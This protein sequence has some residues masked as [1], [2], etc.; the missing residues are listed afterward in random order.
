MSPSTARTPENLDALRRSLEFQTKMNYVMQAI[1]GAGSFA[2]IMPQVEKEILGLINAERVTVFQRNRSEKQLVS[3]H[4][5]AHDVEE[6][7]VPLT[8]SSIVGYVA[9]SQSPVRIDDVYDEAA[10]K[11]IHPNLRFGGRHLDKQTGYRT[12]SIIAVPIKAHE[13]LLGVLQLINHQGGGSFTDKE[14]ECAIELSK[15]MGQR[16][17][18]RLPG[19]PGPLPLPGPD[20]QDLGPGS[21]G[22]AGSGAQGEGPRNPPPALRGHGPAQAAGGLPGALLPGAFHGL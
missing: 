7:R 9:M 3:K 17:P 15:V 1:H 19:H 4:H 16:F 10:L 20:A 8:A 22:D 18:L 12:C 21:G 14:L 13:V 11:R 5:S 6:I 2:E